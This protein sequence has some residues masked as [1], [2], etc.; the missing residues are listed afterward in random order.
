MK[1]HIRKILLL[2]AV[3]LALSIPLHAQPNSPLVGSRPPKAGDEKIVKSAAQGYLRVF[4]PERQIYEPAAETFVWENGNYR[5]RPESGEKA[6]TW[7]H[8]RPLALAPGNYVVQIRDE[9][10]AEQIRVS[11]KPGRITSVWLNDSDRPEFTAPDHSVLVRDAYGD[12]I[13][14][15]AR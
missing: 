14:Y 3:T 1:I 11:I 10:Y 2:A 15:R 12:F 9:Q 4:T 13:G 8:R 7:F 5:V 6:R